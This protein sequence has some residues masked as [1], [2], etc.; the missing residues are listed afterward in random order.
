MKVSPRLDLVARFTHKST[1]GTESLLDQFGRDTRVIVDRAQQKYRVTGSYQVTPRVRVKGRVELT[2]VAYNLLS[3]SERGYLL[4]QD[5]QYKVSKEISLDARLIF[6]HTDSYDS[7]LYEYESD[8]RGV[9]S[10]PSLYGRG[11][12]W[13]LVARYNIAGLLALSAKYSETQ[14]EGVTALGSGSTEIQGD[15]DNRL[16][17]Q[18][19]F[20]W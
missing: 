10:N 18:I 7:R 5:L 17:V 11:R 8:L 4:Y 19:D 15:L 6:F 14:K 13:Y 3:R 12:R 2:H 1:E 20:T 16:A 9:F